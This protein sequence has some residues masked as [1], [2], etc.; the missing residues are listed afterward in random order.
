MNNYK[1]VIRYIE[2]K[3]RASNRNCLLIASSF[4]RMLHPKNYV[5]IKCT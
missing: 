2:K 5:I 4:Q 3:N 1:I